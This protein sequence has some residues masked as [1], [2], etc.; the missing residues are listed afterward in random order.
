MNMSGLVQRRWAVL[1]G[2]NEYDSPAFSNLSYCV[3]DVTSLSDLLSQV[4]YTVVCLHDEVDRNDRLP[5]QKYIEGSLRN[6]KGQFGAED[7]LLVYFACHGTRDSDGTPKLI[8]SDTVQGPEMLA[9]TTVAVAD[10]ERWMRESGAGQLVLMLDACHMGQGTDERKADVVSDFEEGVK[11]V[12]PKGFALLAS[13]TAAQTSR[14]FGKLQHGLFSYCVLNGLAGAARDANRSQITIGAL[15]QYVREALLQASMS[16]GVFQ[17]AQERSQ[18]DLNVDDIV[19]ADYEQ[20]SP[21]ENSDDSE[22]TSDESAAFIGRSEDVQ[23]SN[24]LSQSE[25]QPSSLMCKELRKDLT[26]CEADYKAVASQRRYESNPV[27]KNNLTRQLAD[28]AEQIGNIK[29]DMT[30]LGCNEG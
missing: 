12:L 9:E 15:K 3:N 7:L 21:P 30:K 22:Q 19:L 24:S 20:Y 5:R 27:T 2:I 26:A 29:Q 13:S 14:E 11:A 18:G 17:L 25:T 28:L 6:L 8:A 10:V 23:P 1:V 4:G 16:A